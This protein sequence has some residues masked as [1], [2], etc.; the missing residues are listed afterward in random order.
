M[1]AGFGSGSCWPVVP[2][3]PLGQDDSEDHHPPFGTT[4]PLGKSPRRW[5]CRLLP[6]QP[7]DAPAETSSPAQ[8]GKGVLS[9][10]EP[11][12]VPCAWGTPG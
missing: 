2:A 3:E 9:A 8:G 11:E 5:L 6:K 1:G 7:C 4:F 12:S 10:C